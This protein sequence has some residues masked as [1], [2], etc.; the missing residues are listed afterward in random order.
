MKDNSRAKA[1]MM[2]SLTN[3]KFYGIDLRV[4]DLHV[5]NFAIDVSLLGGLLA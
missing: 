5:T 1:C 3:A 4:L 2:T